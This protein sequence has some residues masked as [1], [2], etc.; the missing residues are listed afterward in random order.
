MPK[1]LWK[2]GNMLYPLPVVM[3]SMADRDGKMNIIT[4]AWAGTV[5]TNPPMVSISVR[6]ERYSHPILEDT[7][8]FVVNLT[9]RQLVF[10]TDYCGVKSG[11]D[12]DKFKK[13]NLTPLK[14]EYVK[15]PLIAES[16]VN[17]ECRVKRILRLGSHDMFLADVA[18]VHAEEKYMDENHKF[19]LEWAEPIV[20]SH[21][22]YL[23]C[24]EQAGT[25]GF[26]VKKEK[27]SAHNKSKKNDDGGKKSEWKKHRREK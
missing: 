21:G 11:R 15:A 2:P 5:C 12:V 6:P 16:P 18:A 10:A 25:F 3:V 9:T 24:G 14:A 26:S 20:Y 8:E 1:E 4:I 23:C 27:K 7:G 17:I 22:A 13:L 19:H